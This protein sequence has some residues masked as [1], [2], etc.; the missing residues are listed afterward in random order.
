[1]TMSEPVI[2]NM[3]RQDYMYC[4]NEFTR[5]SRV[6]LEGYLTFSENLAKRYPGYMLD[7]KTHLIVPTTDH[8]VNVDELF[9][10][11][12]S[13]DVERY[14]REKDKFFGPSGRYT[15]ENAQEQMSIMFTTF[16]RS[17]NSMMRKYF[18]NITG[19]ATGSDLGLRHSPN[20]AL[21]YSVSKGEGMM[22]N[23]T[24]IKKSH[25]PMTIPF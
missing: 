9:A 23:E 6:R 14:E 13:K 8:R 16:P 3:A 17:G 20:V 18:E 19:L 10:L 15:T 21:Q 25:Y 7:Q 24:L 5:F 12:R 1:M 22:G 2:T 11:F 4:D